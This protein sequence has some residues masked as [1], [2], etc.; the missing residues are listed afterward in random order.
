M[1]RPLRWPPRPERRAT[2]P[3]F[4]GLPVL[5][6]AACCAVSPAA[7]AEPSAPPVTVTIAYLT[8]AYP[9]LPPLS[10][11]LSPAR[12]KGL[13]G[14]RMA[15]GESNRTG[16]FTGKHFELV[17]DVVGEADDVAAEA[18]RLL[19]AGRKIIIAD[20]EARDLLAVA[21]LAEAKDA[22]LL[23]ARTS[24]D[25]LRGQ[26]C[27][28]NSFHLL[29]SLAMR[30]DALGQFFAWKRWNR[31]FLLQ[32]QTPADAEFARAIRRAAGRFGAKIVED[33]T[34]AFDPGSR[35]TDTGHEQIQA[36]MP[37][38]TQI[39]PDYDVLVV[40]DSADTFGEYLL[41]NTTKPR[42]V[43]GTHGLVA[44]A[45]HRSFE[46]YAATQMQH[47][48]EKLA[49]RTMTERD[50]GAWLAVRAVGEAA[51][52]DDAAGAA[53]IRRSFES[54][55]FRVAAYKGESLS[56][57]AWDHQLRQPVILAGPLMLVAMSPQDGFLHPK[58]VTDTLG[59]DE[60]ETQCDF[61]S[62]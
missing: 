49:G 33:R 9:E 10:L 46:E 62:S 40:A 59:Y 1:V 48:F 60:P 6:L 43:A 19:A 15:I 5:L 50:Y 56:F 20:L 24:D 28:A 29:P 31:W 16:S 12:E 30:A 7:R 27:R 21:D 4:P 39:G 17:E 53:Q 55:R 45:W 18:K 8:K 3:G 14:A 54:D 32:G 42:L 37:M 34:Y 25:A 35:R 36:Q 13:W 26:D 11:V 22:V 58:F 61:H 2:K 38:E 52:R 51:L 41:F 47:R 57:R 44:V 23:D